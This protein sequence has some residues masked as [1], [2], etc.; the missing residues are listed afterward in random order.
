VKI[1]RVVSAGVLLAAA[2]THAAELP[3]VSAER[4][5]RETS[6]P[7]VRAPAQF[8]E[9]LRTSR[10]CVLLFTDNQVL[11]ADAVRDLPTEGESAMAVVQ[12]AP[13]DQPALCLAAVFSGG[14]AAAWL[15]EGW[16]IES[17]KPVELVSMGKARMNN[18]VVPPRTLGNAIAGAY[19]RFGK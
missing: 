8:F 16:K 17:G 7:S 11:R 19:A 9:C 6:A 3:C 13:A 2:A 5:L 18:D 12:S 1:I 4:E 14:S 10:V 15:F